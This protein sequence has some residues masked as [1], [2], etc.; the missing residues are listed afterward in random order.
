MENNSKNLKK[1]KKINPFVVIVI[2][3]GLMTLPF[4][5]F[6]LDKLLLNLN[7]K[8]LFFAEISIVLVGISSALIIYFT[9]FKS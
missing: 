3:T 7:D 1:K 8:I 6:M 5:A 9:F 4:I 2:L